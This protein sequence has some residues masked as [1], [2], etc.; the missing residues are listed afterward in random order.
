MAASCMMAVLSRSSGDFKKQW[1]K[2]FQISHIP[3]PSE[4]V[5]G[6]QFQLRQGPQA[7][8]VL[9]SLPLTVAPVHL[10]RRQCE[11]HLPARLDRCKTVFHSELCFD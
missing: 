7:E 3:G 9:V 6:H 11:N 8:M 2:V 4:W 1:S 5:T 10:N